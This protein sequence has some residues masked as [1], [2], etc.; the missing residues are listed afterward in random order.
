MTQEFNFIALT[1]P[2][3][4]DPA[5]PIAAS[6]AG[7][8]GVIDLQ[9]VQDE[10]IAFAAVAK[11]ARFARHACGIKL[12]TGT[13]EFAGRVISELPT[14]IRYV[15]LSLAGP[16]IPRH[17][18]DLLR[19]RNLRI[20]L[21]VTELEQ[22]LL[23]QDAGV[24][25][26]IAKGHEA[27]GW[28]GEET[29]FIL[30]QRL[31]AHLSI[32]VWAHG[33]IGPHTVAACYVAGAAGAVLD[34]QLALTRESALPEKAKA[35]IA[36]MDGSETVC[37]GAKN[38][39]S[40]RLYAR[41]KLPGLEHLREMGESLGR[42][43]LTQSVIRA[44]WRQEVRARVGW[45]SPDKQ[46][47]PLGQDAAFA[48]PLAGNHKTVGGVLQALRQEVATHVEAA[49][50]HRPLSENSPLAR[51]H[52]TRYPVVQGPMTRVSDNAAFASE[53]AKGGALPF[54]A[55]ALMR[56]PEVKSLLEETSSLLGGRPWGVGILGF[57]PLEL[58]QEQMEV[59]RAFKPSYALIAGGRPD[60]AM[61][62]EQAGIPTYLHVP[63]PN[64][65]RLFI[66]NGARRFVFEG[67]ECGGHVGPRSSFVLW[68]LMID[69]LLEHLPATEMKDCHVLFAGGI[70][71]AVSSSMVSTM[72]APLAALGAKVGVLLGTAYLFTE[73]AVTTGAI[74]EGFQQ[75]AIRC[76]QTALLESGPGHA[77]RCA[78]TP[79]VETFEREKQQLAAAGKSSEELR[80]ALEDLNVG[81]LRI[82]SKG[83]N[84]HPQY[85]RNPGAPKLIEVSEEKQHAEGMYMIGQVAALRDSTCTVEELHREVSV[86]GSERL[87]L[88]AEPALSRTAE[89]RQ[90]RPCD[91]AIVGM[92]CLLPKAPS[93]QTYWENILTKVDAIGEIPPTRFDW[94]RYYDAD[95]HAPDKI[96]SKWGGFLDDFA[97]DPVRYGMPP[98]T[99]P[100]IEP[101]QIL[102]LEAVRAALEDA[103]Y[104]DRPFPRDHTSVVIGAGGGVADLGNQ[105]VVRSA[106]PGL[107]ETARGD[108]LEKLPEWSEDSFPGILLN[109]IAG[110]V[111]NRFDLGGVNY[112]VDAACASS[113][114]AIY[115]AT[116]ELEDGTS[117]VVITG[118][119]DTV[120]NA[121]AYLAFSKTHALSPTGHCRTFDE[122]ADG[123]VISEGIAMLVL[124]RLADAERDGDRI[125]AVIKGVAGSSDGRG[126]GLTAPR[127]EGQALALQRAYTKAG[128]SPATVGLVEAHG[129]GTVAGDQAEVATLKNVFGSAGAALQGCAL[130][131]VKSMIGHTKCTAGAAGL[132][133]V[134][135][136]L[137]HKVLPPTMHVEKPNVKARFHESPFYINTELRPWI[138]DGGVEHPRRAAVSA[139]GFGGT[140]FHAVIEEYTGNFEDEASSA[141]S[142]TWPSELLLFAGDS[143]EQIL[144]SVKS[145]AR[146]LADGATPALRDLA[147]TLWQAARD[148]AGL[149]LAIIATS[150]GDLRQKLDWSIDN[151]QSPGRVHLSNPGGVYFTEQQLS[152]QGEIAF[153]FPG[154]GSQ[155]TDM[156]RELSVHFPEVREQFELADRVLAGK[157]PRRLSSYVFPPPRFGAEEEKAHLQAL[158]QTNVAQPAIGAASIGLFR[159]LHSLNVRPTMVAGHSYGEY[160]A[161][162]CA[163][164]FS[165]E[166]LYNLSEARGRCI[167]ETAE[168][169]LGT[170]AAVSEG[171]EQVSKILA[172]LGEDVWIA[173]FNAPKQT[174]LSGKRQRV[175][176]AI[177]EF[178]RRGVQARRIPAACAFHS[179]IIAPA[180]ER[181]A[182]L[183]SNVEFGVPHLAVF[184]N[185]SAAAY[186]TDP[187]AVADL[188]AEHLVK[189]VRFADEVEAMYSAGARIFV[190]VGPRNVLSGLVEQILG[191]RPHLAVA[192]DVSGRSGLLQLQH[193][194]GQLATHGAALNLDRLFQGRQAR[195]LNFSELVEQTRA[196]VLPPTTWLVNG[197]RSTPLRA[198]ASM[199]S[200]PPPPKASATPPRRDEAPAH[201][202]AQA[203]ALRPVSTQ[204]TSVR[205]NGSSPLASVA[206]QGVS[207]AEYLSPPTNNP[208]NGNGDAAL[209]SD[210]DAV[211]LQFQQLMGRF[212]ETQQ[213]V[214]LAYLRGP[215]HETALSPDVVRQLDQPAASTPIVPPAEPLRVTGRD[216]T[217]PPESM[218]GAPP[219]SGTSKPAPLTGAEVSSVTDIRQLLLGL[220]SEKTGYPIEMLDL[221][222]NLE[223]DLGIDS[224]KRVEILGALERRTGLIGADVERASKLSTLGSLADFLAARQSTK[225]CPSGLPGTESSSTARKDSAETARPFAASSPASASADV[226]RADEVGR[227]RSNGQQLTQGTEELTRKLIAIVS[228]RT[229]YPPEMLD[230]DLNMEAD[231][232]IDSIKR[233]EI[234]SSFQR[235]CLSL[236]P[237]DGHETM[238]KLSGAKTLRAVVDRIG[239][240]LRPARDGKGDAHADSTRP[241]AAAPPPQAEVGE[242]LPRFLL[243][244]VA[245]PLDVTVSAPV[246]GKLFLITDDERGVAEQLAAAL[247]ERGGR[248]AVVRMRRGHEA[249]GDGIYTS[250]LTDPTAVTELI[251]KIHQQ[252]GQLSGVVHLLPLKDGHEFETMSL[253]VWR[254][255]LQAETKSLLLLAQAT[256]SDFKRAEGDLWFVA[257]TEMGGTFA[258]DDSDGFFAPHH[259]GIGGFV[260]T[261]AIEWPHVRHKVLDFNADVSARERA[262]LLLTEM[263]ARDGEV[264]VGYE[265]SRRVVLRAT[266]SRLS[267]DRPSRLTL[268]SSS[269][270]LVT[271]GARGITAEVACEL[272]QR[273]RPTLVI[274]GRSPLPGAEESLQTSGSASPRELKAALIEQMRREGKTP[275]PAAVE[276]AYSRLLQDREM[277]DYLARMRS[278]G[279]TVHYHQ[280]DVRDEIA[281]GELMDGVY[282]SHGRIDGVLHGAG[283]IEDKLVEDKSPDSFDRVL[284]TKA[285]SSLI[286]SRKLRPDSLK[287]LVF[288]SSISGR[289]GNRGQIDYAAAN[290]LINKL[291][292]YL[293]RRWPGRVVSINWGPWQKIGMASEEVQRQFAERNVQIIRPAA[294]RDALDRELRFGRKGE[295]EIVIGGGPW[296]TVEGYEVVIP[297]ALSPLPGGVSR[298]VASGD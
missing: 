204:A 258:S 58:R 78:E 235:E 138:H 107:L 143:R 106:L 42:S 279:A 181:L 284:E 214:M 200:P 135:L 75:E 241:N 242:E 69:A 180:R 274:V 198:A 141:V 283:I 280:V 100:S 112:T 157:F 1:P 168:Q 77:T 121:F 199:K 211:M 246:S 197:G 165:L 80:A 273:Y 272:A 290:E 228:E 133:K 144:S 255:R 115:M 8:I 71:D 16:D 248:T 149:K 183:L 6:R 46:V 45:E 51:S 164:V 47:W 32:P 254:E 193:A 151:L 294:G 129:T 98:N 229:G 253:A 79:F 59:I 72:A 250:D 196:G 259:G 70:H 186:P 232:G 56:A 219:E 18:L 111:A 175:E 120:Q 227:A 44:R 110:R 36:R 231:L 226:R 234:L 48:A 260:K 88:A 131:S 39:G 28:V 91:V 142:Q 148:R 285:V 153:L 298:S 4:P 83:V 176:Q 245:A 177:E 184:S 113:L 23:G 15:I 74:K 57:V 117:D 2:G 275:A 64:L 85:G 262:E 12:D 264:E 216:E 162:C 243:S 218:V 132:I 257:A 60:Q 169:D 134:A 140:N 122:S 266:P 288:F 265:G 95:P 167:I 40:I 158:T 293:D 66:E 19:G 30:L 73:E 7:G 240:F 61:T 277:R 256:S 221:E 102:M 190:E 63:S 247:R 24:D 220:V 35:V 174:V 261:L 103:G 187:V 276:A 50:A 81:R 49:R 116:R 291:A 251:R 55:L 195:S 34:F 118:A 281:F 237:S 136:A 26:V 154:Q 224:I 128:L 270:L 123:I 289:F 17:L 233:V 225:D 22:A 249:E 152:L 205:G 124:K 84:R 189:P 156:L 20:L 68:N 192:S 173:N 109:V 182:G 119:G 292:V 41:P 269:V 252:Q 191:E 238:E 139:F 52:G 179:P 222:S 263:A 244:A 94:R 126:K 223:A 127:P 27:G 89:G 105:Y 239:D 213:Q 114:A 37:L 13:E 202:E 76:S 65:L 96:Y 11:L 297:P 5:I 236:G 207:P 172:S 215:A 206:A 146:A 38:S 150:L 147:Y 125:Y 90:E 271:G 209:S 178:A 217:S 99:L 278:S 10:H 296:A 9:Y 137:H 212:L 31:L 62:L 286:L 163:G 161:L 208:P 145:L 210:A 130:G 93:L 230:L 282:R 108:L 87:D 101:L 53:V 160:A 54:L 166:T 14:E 295:V 268:D 97:F 201:Q 3:L 25:G 267:T 194:L 287:F 21:E 29:S 104:M 185:T 159:L 92:A 33:G 170:M 171:P 43:S 203:P 86:K 82:A 67:R 155:Y 188:L